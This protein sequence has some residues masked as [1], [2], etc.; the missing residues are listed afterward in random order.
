MGAVDLAALDGAFSGMT[1]NLPGVPSILL[2]D[3]EPLLLA[4]ASEILS[5]E[6]YAVTSCASAEEALALVATGYRPDMVVT[7]QSMPGI[8]GSVLATRLRDEAGISAIV[9]ASGQE[10]SGSH[11]FATLFKPFRASELI[12]KVHEMAPMPTP[13]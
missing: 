9:I 7:D 6:G 10:D 2:V 4:M 11:G 1:V 5:E 13:G 8:S 12:A 3:D